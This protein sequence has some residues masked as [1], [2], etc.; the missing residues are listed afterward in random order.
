MEPENANLVAQLAELRDE[1]ASL[2]V[3]AKRRRWPVWK[4][5][6]ALVGVLSVGAVGFG[7]ASATVPDAA[8]IIHACRDNTYG[9][10]RI[11]DTGAGGACTGS[12]TAA[13]WG[14]GR[15]ASYYTHTSAAT[16][17]APGG[18]GA[19]TVLCDGS[20]VAT[21]GG[22]STSTIYVVITGSFPDVD[23][24]RWVAVGHNA[25]AAQHSFVATVVCEHVPS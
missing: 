22:F 11:I 20:D 21:G 24:H 14:S 23:G 12:E 18:D 13:A 19:A 2:K 10:V 7:I 25:S 5:L 17:L 3:Q 1:V 16:T 6:G 8:G 9:Y 15:P 4:R